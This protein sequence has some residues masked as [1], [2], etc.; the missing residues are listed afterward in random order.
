MKLIHS[1]LLTLLCFYVAGCSTQGG[2]SASITIDQTAK[3]KTQPTS[4]KDTWGLD[5]LDHSPQLISTGQVVFPT[6]LVNAGVSEL[7]L[8]LHIL[9]HED[10]HVSLASFNGSSCSDLDN[11]IRTIAQEARF[12]PPLRNGKVV[13]AE[14][15]WPVRIHK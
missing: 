13:K 1:V 2:P 3:P 5:T 6:S 15:I 4:E 7:K 12:T 8:E 9:I 10:G 14:F 11:L